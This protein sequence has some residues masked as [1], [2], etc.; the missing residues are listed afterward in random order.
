MYIV[1]TDKHP[2]HYLKNAGTKADFSFVDVFNGRLVESEFSEATHRKCDGV[3]YI[4]LLCDGVVQN[5]ERHIHNPKSK[6]NI[7]IIDSLSTLLEWNSEH[8]IISFILRISSLDYVDSVFL[9]IHEDLHNKHLVSSF[10]HIATCIIHM[11]DIPEFRN[12]PL[13]GSYHI[14]QKRKNG[15]V[16]RSDEHYFQGADGKLGIYHDS[17][18]QKKKEEVVVE[19]TKEN[20]Y[21]DDP[22]VTFN[23]GITDQQ[24][25]ARDSVVLPYMKTR[26]DMN[27]VQE[28]EESMIY[29]DDDDD[30]FEGS[31][32]DDDLDI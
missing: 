5:I 23:L 28:H 15:K 11:Q 27:P 10:E 2:R 1:N 32:P 9:R 3:E 18:V 6:K 22:D 19:E 26:M 24:K 4:E 14:I 7:V 13:H 12:M 17:A 25:E 29:I 8:D 20:I 21:E 16:T 30:A 31:D